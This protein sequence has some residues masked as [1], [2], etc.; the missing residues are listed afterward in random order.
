MSWHEKYLGI[1]YEQKNCAELVSFVLRNELN[2]YSTANYIDGLDHAN[3]KNSFD[4]YSSIVCEIGVP[5]DK[6]A[7]VL[8]HG[9]DQGHI[10]IV[11]MINNQPYVLHSMRSRGS[12]LQTIS[13]LIQVGY[14]VDG[15]YKWL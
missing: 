5:T 14:K 3:S 2:L 15:F 10:G 11:C 13:A 12:S 8:S 9:L 7:V 1:S 4:D 6:C